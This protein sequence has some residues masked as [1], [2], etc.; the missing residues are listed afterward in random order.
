MRTLLTTATLVL[1]LALPAVADEAGTGQAGDVMIHDGW[2]RAS[3]GSNPNS[4]AYMTLENH[5]DTADKL[6]KAASP[7]AEKAEL[8]THIMENDIAKMRPVEAIEVAP[9]EPTVLQPGGLH[10]M[11]MGLTGKLEEGGTMPVT[12]TFENAGE[13]TLDLPI[14]SAT[15]AKMN[16]DGDMK[17]G[18]GMKHGHSS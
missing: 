2:A 14:K 12:L 11:L 15:G 4:A 18:D 1:S 17:H 8:H 10:V 9:G 3:L 5:G 7:A 13:V 16:H 6:I